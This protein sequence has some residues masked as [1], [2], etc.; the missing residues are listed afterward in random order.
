MKNLFLLLFLF[1]PLTASFACGNEYEETINSR[2]KI[3]EYE[4]FSLDFDRLRHGFDTSS[5]QAKR[6]YLLDLF[7]KGKGDYRDSSDLALIEMKIGSRALAVSILEKL[8]TK[9]PDEYNIA[10]NLG[11]AYELTGKNKLAFEFITKAM[12]LNPDS[13]YGSEWIHLKI[14]QEKMKAH[15]DYRKILNLQVNDLHSSFAAY[16][17]KD[18]LQP[19]HELS[20]QLMYQLVERINFIAP[21]DPVVSQLLIDQGDLMA[22]TSVELARDF[23]KLAL[24]YDPK[25]KKII[26]A[27]LNEV[28]QLL[29]Y[30]F[31]KL[32]W[33]KGLSLFIFLGLVF[34]ISR[35]IVLRRR[36]RKLNIQS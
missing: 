22:I 9:Y 27:R 15:P 35:R 29:M 7:N 12:K 34:F 5:L 3:I 20:D 14:L 10:A 23:Y 1:L 17:A 32:H 28:T 19:L 18:S 26:D 13:H 8:Y 36:K 30:K 16:H 25:N 2:G 6:K 11:T 21:E 31:I 33:G 4:M 24:Q